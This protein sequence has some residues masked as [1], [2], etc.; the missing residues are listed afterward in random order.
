MKIWMLL[1]SDTFIAYWLNRPTWEMLRDMILK[2][3]ENVGMVICEEEA[4]LIA[5]NLLEERD[6]HS[7]YILKTMQENV[8]FD[9]QLY[10]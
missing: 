8:L 3:V 1:Y 10:G 7:A 6:N 4:E 9:K 5:F 2:D